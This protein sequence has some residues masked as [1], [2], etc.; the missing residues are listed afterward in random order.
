MAPIAALIRDIAVDGDAKALVALLVDAAK[1]RVEIVHLA[2][3]GMKRFGKFSEKP[4]E[5]D[6]TLGTGARAIAIDGDGNIWVATNAWG[7]VSVL[8][9]NQDGAPS[10]ESVI[11]AKGR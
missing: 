3:G 2:T 6:P 11:G 7:K 1:S 8:R 10:E 5:N 4:L 9:I